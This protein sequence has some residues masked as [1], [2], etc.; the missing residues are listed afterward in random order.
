[1]DERV[2]QVG[3]MWRMERMLMGLQRPAQVTRIDAAVRDGRHRSDAVL[4]IA[5][6]GCEGLE[7][8]VVEGPAW[9]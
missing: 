5:T 3:R 9:W 7:L 1:M 4:A 8:R 6:I 2:W